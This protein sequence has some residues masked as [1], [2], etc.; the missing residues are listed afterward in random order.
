MKSNNFVSYRYRDASNK[1]FETILKHCEIVEKAS[2]DEAY[3]DLTSI[4][5]ERL[6]DFDESVDL[7]NLLST[8]FVVGSYSL[9]NDSGKF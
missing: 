7:L 8:T 3:L 2:I 5:H 1:I 6:K 4:V 9:E